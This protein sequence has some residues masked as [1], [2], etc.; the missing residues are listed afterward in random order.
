MEI[1][2]ILKL[3]FFLTIHLHLLYK[4]LTFLLNF[5]IFIFNFDM[6]MSNSAYF[7]QITASSLISQ[8][9]SWLPESQSLFLLAAALNPGRLRTPRWHFCSRSGK[10]KWKPFAHL[11]ILFIH[12]LPKRANW[13]THDYFAIKRENT[14]S[15]SY[16]DLLIETGANALITWDKA[17]LPTRADPKLAIS[18]GKEEK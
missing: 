5:L 17:F 18:P 3:S 9:S 16:E 12:Q 7:F 8:Y 4:F 13:K 1:T 6:L 2:S 14:I 10:N 15:T 11:S